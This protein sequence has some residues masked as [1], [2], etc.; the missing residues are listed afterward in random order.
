MK[1]LLTSDLVDGLV[2]YKCGWEMDVDE[3]T[4][5]TLIAAGHKLAPNQDG[6]AK[7]NPEMYDG[8]CIPIPE[9]ALPK[10]KKDAPKEA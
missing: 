1:I 5:A 10:A 6:P 8:G 7:K 9:Q 2:T 4:G 3:P